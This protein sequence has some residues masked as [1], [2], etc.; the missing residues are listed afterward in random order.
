MRFN[1]IKV[2]ILIFGSLI[3]CAIK[4]DII[5]LVLCEYDEKCL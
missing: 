5:Y 4:I 2:N 1:T 3:F